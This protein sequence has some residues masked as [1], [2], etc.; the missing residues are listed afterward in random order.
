MGRVENEWSCFRA[1]RFVFIYLMRNHPFSA[2]P[3]AISQHCCIDNQNIHTA[4]N[5]MS[6]LCVRDDML[7]F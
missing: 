7:N 5:Y 3:M 2:L 4:N 6:L 1:V